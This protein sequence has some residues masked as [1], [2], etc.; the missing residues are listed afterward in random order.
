[1][2]IR[3]LILL[4]KNLK[5]KIQI[6]IKT[7]KN[8]LIGFDETDIRSGLIFDE[9]TGCVFGLPELVKIENFNDN[10]NF[11]ILKVKVCAN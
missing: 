7:I 10:F 11:I 2:I 6:L 8:H 9:K 4:L 1:L 3:I 5:V